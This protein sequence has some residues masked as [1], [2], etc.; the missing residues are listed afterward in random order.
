[1]GHETKKVIG[2]KYSGELAA[3]KRF[4]GY[5]D[6]SQKAVREA[7]HQ[8]DEVFSRLV[9][10]YQRIPLD[11]LENHI[12]EIDRRQLGNWSGDAE[13]VLGPDADETQPGYQP[14]IW[15][16]DLSGLGREDVKRFCLGFP[17]H[18]AAQ[19]VIYK[20]GLFVSFLIDNGRDDEYE[21]P[22]GHLS[23]DFYGF[24]EGNR[25]YVTV[26]GDVFGIGTGMAGGI[27]RLKGDV[28]G[29]GGVAMIG[30]KLIV[31]GDCHGVVGSW[32]QGGEIHV[33]GELRKVDFDKIEAG[34]IYHKGKLIMD[35]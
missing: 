24:C 28:L 1:M 27:I 4:T 12:R 10:L 8:E 21:L 16:G 3:R 30:G 34:R 26:I 23:P 35:K 5:K 18:T 14:P 25:K 7:G 15:H 19:G 32:M 2:R 6:G 33:E 11:K 9:S 22:I 31:E 20:F 17:A 29:S 13:A